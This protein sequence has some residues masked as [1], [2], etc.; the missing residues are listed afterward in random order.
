L[1]RHRLLGLVHGVIV[2]WLTLSWFCWTGARPVGST[3]K[4]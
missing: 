4:T 1:V 2:P 3:E